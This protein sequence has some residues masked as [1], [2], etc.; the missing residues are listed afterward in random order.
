[1]NE[2]EK[3]LIRLYLKTETEIINE[4]ARRRKSTGFKTSLHFLPSVYN[5]IQQKV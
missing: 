4:I 3:R 1:M 2:Y 5:N